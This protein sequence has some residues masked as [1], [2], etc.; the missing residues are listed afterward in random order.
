M[1]LAAETPEI[2][3]LLEIC[4]LY[5][6]LCVAGSAKRK[7][8]LVSGGEVS[9]ESCCFGEGV[10]K[11]KAICHFY[12]LGCPAV[13][14]VDAGGSAEGNGCKFDYFL[15][16]GDVVG[17]ARLLGGEGEGESARDKC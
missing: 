12:A 7:H 16:C 14:L 5:P 15:G 13:P 11:V 6:I 10:F 4:I 2:G 9:Y 17:G 1:H 8:Y 3:Y